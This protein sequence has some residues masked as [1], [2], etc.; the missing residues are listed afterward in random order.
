[1]VQD[2]CNKRKEYESRVIE[3]AD[4]W[5]NSETDETE[6]LEARDKS[7]KDLWDSKEKQNN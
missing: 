7:E 5:K 4:V 6:Y 2:R 1:M 3:L